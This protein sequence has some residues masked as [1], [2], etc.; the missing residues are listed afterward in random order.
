MKTFVVSD[1]HFS[2]KTTLKWDMR[3]RFNTKIGVEEDLIDK[4]ILY[5]DTMTMNETIISNWNSV[6]SKDDIVYH[7]GDVSFDNPIKTIDILSRLNGIIYLVK[8]NHD[9]WRDI[10]KFSD[11]FADIFDYKEIK[12]DFLGKQYHI[13][14]MHYPIAS[15]NRKMYGSIHLFGHCHGKFTQPGK[16]FDVGIDTEFA[17]FAPINIE[18]AIERANSLDLAL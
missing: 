15:W 6:V 1:T 16:C 12:H 10:K 11:R 3:K 13:I 5:R 14:M 18:N 7:L 9:K 17:N 2:H 8:G 4:K